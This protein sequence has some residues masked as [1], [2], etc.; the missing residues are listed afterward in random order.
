MGGPLTSYEVSSR[1]GGTMLNRTLHTF[2]IGTVREKK[3][4]YEYD[5]LSLEVIATF[6]PFAVAKLYYIFYQMSAKNC[7]ED[8]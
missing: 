8:S 3:P 5:L 7:K 2:Y 6:I 1:S 4:A